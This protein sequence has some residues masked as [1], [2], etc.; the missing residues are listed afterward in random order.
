[1][2]H[3]RSY[4][5]VEMSPLARV[6]LER[7][8]WFYNPIAEIFIDRVERGEAL[9]D[10]TKVVRYRDARGRPLKTLFHSSNANLG[11]ILCGQGAILAPGNRTARAD[12]GWLYLDGPAACRA[13]AQAGEEG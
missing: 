4:T 11:P 1:M 5:Y 12:G 9:P 3:A 8:P 6:V 10:E 7:A 13:G 2:W